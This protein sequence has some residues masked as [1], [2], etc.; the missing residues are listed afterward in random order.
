MLGEFKGNAL[1]LRSADD[2]AAV[3]GKEVKPSV[4]V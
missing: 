1:G 3:G 4:S 2:E